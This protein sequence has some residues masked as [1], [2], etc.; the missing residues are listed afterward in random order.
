MSGSCK[1]EMS[2]LPFR[3]MAEENTRFLLS[4]MTSNDSVPCLKMKTDIAIRPTLLLAD[5]NPAL[6]ATVVEMLGSG[7]RV[8]ASLSNG[9]SVLNQIDK[10]IC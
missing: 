4:E 8:V 3:Q 5:D 1:V 10:S 6:L 9:A 2:K 7:Y